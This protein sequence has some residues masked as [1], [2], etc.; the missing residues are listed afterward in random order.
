M[1][2]RVRPEIQR[3]CARTGRADSGKRTASAIVLAAAFALLAPPAPSAERTVR[4]GIYDNSPKVSL[5]A[6]GRPEGVFVDVFEAI[7]EREGWKTE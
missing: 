4:I 3:P 1:G 2:K 5:S 7:A 6:D